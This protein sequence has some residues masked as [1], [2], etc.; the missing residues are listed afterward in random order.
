MLRNE[1]A[2][3]SARAARPRAMPTLAASEVK[4]RMRFVRERLGESK[5]R[6]VVAC[7]TSRLEIL[8]YLAGGATHAGGAP[9]VQDAEGAD[10]APAGPRRG[11]GTRSRK[12]TTTTNGVAVEKPSAIG[13][14]SSG[15]VASRAPFPSQAM[16]RP[17]RCQPRRD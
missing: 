16:H 7:P 12:A 3:A 17:G 8:A 1:A 15:A 4:R 13:A 9:I 14:R 6:N 5:P 10:R 11:K 2:C